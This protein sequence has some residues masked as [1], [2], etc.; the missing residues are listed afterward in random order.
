MTTGRRVAWGL[1]AFAAVAILLNLVAVAADSFRGSQV[2]SGPTGSSHVTTA[3]GLA[4]YHDLLLAAGHEVSVL[5]T[6][7]RPGTLDPS[8]TLVI[9]SPEEFTLD[10]RQVDLIGDFLTNGGRLVLASTTFFG[11][12][13]TT[14]LDPAPRLGPAPPKEV[15]SLLPVPETAGVATVATSGLYAWKDSGS[16]LPIVGTDGV[17]VVAV[18]SIGRGRLVL[19]ADPAVLSNAF[20]GTNAPL[21]LAIV[22]E[23]GRPIVFDEHVHGYGSDSAITAIPPR[24]RTALVLLL[25]AALVWLWSIGSRFAPAEPADRVFPPARGLYVDALAASLAR[26]PDLDMSMHTTTQP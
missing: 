1:V 13:A 2:V 4:A 11:D 17:T 9:A 24:W 3:D 5:N 22:G 25:L 14:L 16:A 18:A 7:I 15:T 23:P 12:V 20:I 19:L 26:T 8:T 10:E 6:P 21:G